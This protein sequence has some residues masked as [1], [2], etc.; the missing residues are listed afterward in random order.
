MGDEEKPPLEFA[1]QVIA[2]FAENLLGK[3]GLK[4]KDY[5]VIRVAFRKV[6]GSWFELCHG[7]VGQIN[8]LT[9]TIRAWGGQQG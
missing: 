8:L 6:G 9:Q 2:L 7:N 5:T 4:P 3:S 1:N